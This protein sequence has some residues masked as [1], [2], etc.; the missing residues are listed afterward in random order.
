MVGE[1]IPFNTLDRIL[2]DT[3]GTGTL[4]AEIIRKL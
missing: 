2:N 1:K 4:S 3:D